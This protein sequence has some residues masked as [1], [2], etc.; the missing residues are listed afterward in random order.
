MYRRNKKEPSLLHLDLISG[1]KPKKDVGTVEKFYIFLI[2]QE[3]AHMQDIVLE[4]TLED[5]DKDKDGKLSIQEFIIDI[6]QVQ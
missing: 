6:W 4:E 5:M 1:A 3:H 2:L